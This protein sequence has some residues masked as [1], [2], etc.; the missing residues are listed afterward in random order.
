MHFKKS[1]SYLVFIFLFS[2][3]TLENIQAAQNGFCWNE[4]IGW[5]NMSGVSYNP[6]IRQLSGSASY[7]QGV[8]NSGFT[9]GEIGF[10][11]QGNL[12][13]TRDLNVNGSGDYNFTGQGFS[14]QIGWVVADH[15]GKDPLIMKS[16]GE[17]SGNFWSNEIG[18]L[19]CSSSVVGAGFVQVWDISGP[20]LTINSP[21][22]NSEL[23]ENFN[24]NVT[25]GQLGDVISMSNANI[26]P[27]PVNH[28]CVGTETV[29]LPISFNTGLEGT[30]Q[31]LVITSTDTSSNITTENL[32]IFINDGDNVDR[33]TEINAPNGGDSN[34]DGIIDAEQ[35]EVAAIENIENIQYNTL[36][37]TNADCGS[38][39][40]FVSKYEADLASQDA[41]HNYPLGLW[42]V[43]FSCGNPGDT[44]DVK[45]ILDKVYDTS[46]WIYKKFNGTNYTDISGIVTYG[47]ENIAGTN[48][49]SINYSITD[50]GPY[51]DDGIAN[52]IIIDPAGPG[53]PPAVSTSGGGSAPTRN[54]Y[55]QVELNTPSN[56]EEDGFHYSAGTEDLSCILEDKNLGNLKGLKEN[57]AYIKING[58]KKEGITKIL[59]TYPI[60][61]EIKKLKVS[62]TP[63]EGEFENK[64][65]INLECGVKDIKN[66][67][68][69][70][71][72]KI[73][74]DNNL[75]ESASENLNNN[76]CETEELIRYPLDRGVG[77]KKGYFED[78]DI[79]DVTF[80][81]AKDLAE[82]DI[83]HGDAET[84]NARLDD[85]VAR[86]EAA[87][88][89]SRAAQHLI[90]Y[91]ECLKNDFP[92]VVSYSWYHRYTQNLKE[93]GIIHGYDDGFY[94]PAQSINKVE[95]YK[96]LAITFGF[97][98]KADAKIKSQ[99]Q[100]T[101]WFMPYEDEL[102]KRNIIPD[103]IQNMENGQLLTRGDVFS[104][105]ARTLAYLDKIEIK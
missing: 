56:L 64:N 7:F 104:L 29:D 67:P 5:I 26:N 12:L 28:T 1:F 51:D 40:S 19:N 31:T 89:I 63:T 46:Q 93:R 10:T 62:Y 24:V 74:L 103:W 18:W 41:S 65:S 20:D 2:F 17:L 73:K 16:S 85:N 13:V 61:G 9:A 91:G 14:E 47:T 90:K 97:T 81:Y 66:N 4:K 27:N 102:H 6:S 38:I 82:Q 77:L 78:A 80:K 100:E 105:V 11:L 32:N 87:K 59:E 22:N 75:H 15:N 43:R 72:F 34:D 94:R 49:T 88:T 48:K 35:T 84:H 69:G 70:S 55:P 30:S 58:I 79:N 23:E 86:A 44:A 60:G 101:E 71:K 99:E 76:L 98:T 36:H 96:I 52:G 57:T 25:C 45:I 21:S 54:Y 92:D 68:S 95:L 8:Y 33:N 42:D 37:S 39:T 83:I 3:F 53:V 50:G